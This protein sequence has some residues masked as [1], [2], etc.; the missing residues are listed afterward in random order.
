MLSLGIEHRH[1]S[2]AVYIAVEKLMKKPL[3]VCQKIL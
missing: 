3:R 2:E 1:I